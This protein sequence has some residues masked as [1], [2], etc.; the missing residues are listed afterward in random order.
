MEPESEVGKRFAKCLSRADSAT[1]SIL[2][3]SLQLS[4]SGT[5]S[6]LGGGQT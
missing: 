5:F 1:D 6:M 3:P 2:A 4:F